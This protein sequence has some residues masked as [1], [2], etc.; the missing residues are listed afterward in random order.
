MTIVG[1]ISSNNEAP[2][3][4]EV[5]R[6]V[7]CS[8]DNHLNLNTRKTKEI[9]FDFWRLKTTLSK[10]QW[11]GGGAGRRLQ[12]PQSAHLR[13]PG[14]VGEHHTHSQI[15]PAAGSFSENLQE[16]QTP[17]TTPEKPL[18]LHHRECANLQVDCRL[19]SPTSGQDLLEPSPL[20]GD[21]HSESYQLALTDSRTAFSLWL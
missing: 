19:S 6:V 11:K 8:S 5:Q 9:I 4:K 21:S 13:G 15:S 14:L 12:V 3:R 16:E 10:R 17:S 18:P 20:M 7:A 1:L 2:Y